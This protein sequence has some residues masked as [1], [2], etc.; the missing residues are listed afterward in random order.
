MK[1]KIIGIALG[2]GVGTFLFAGTSL[3][4]SYDINPWNELDELISPVTVSISEDRSELTE[5]YYWGVSFISDAQNIYDRRKCTLIEFPAN[6]FSPVTNDIT[7]TGLFGSYTVLNLHIDESLKGCESGTPQ[8]LVL[9]DDSFTYTITNA[10]I[11][12]SEG[13]LLAGINNLSGS[14]KGFLLIILPVFIIL[15]FLWFG[16]L[17]LQSRK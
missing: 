11:G 13:V 16:Y 17:F 3:A 6:P 5:G 7:F 4:A 9:L 2:F 14:I 8:E 15:G 1:N 10:I 12:G